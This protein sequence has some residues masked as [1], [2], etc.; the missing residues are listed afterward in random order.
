MAGRQ[1]CSSRNEI[2]LENTNKAPN[3]GQKSDRI[4]RF[5]FY[6]AVGTCNF[7]TPIMNKFN[8]AILPVQLGINNNRDV[9]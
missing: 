6:D 4:N 1:N 5:R 9:L 7:A 8:H 2:A 3:S